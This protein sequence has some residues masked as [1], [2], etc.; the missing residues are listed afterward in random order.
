MATHARHRKPQHNKPARQ[1][2]HIHRVS[3]TVAHQ[4]TA[5]RLSVAAAAGGSSSSSTA[6]DTLAGLRSWVAAA[7][8]YVDPR[9]TSKYYAAANLLSRSC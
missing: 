8:G 5:H 6:G 9:L 3:L 4:H 1:Q 7:G 2:P